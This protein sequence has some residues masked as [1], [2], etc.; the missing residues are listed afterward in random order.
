MLTAKELYSVGGG[1]LRYL[2]VPRLLIGE[3]F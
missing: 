2:L 1:T 3:Q